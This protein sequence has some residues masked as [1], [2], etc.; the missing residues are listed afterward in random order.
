M[1]TIA[2]RRHARAHTRATEGAFE[3]RHRRALWALLAIT[4]VLYLVGLSRNAWA[5]D[6]YAAAVQAGTR[7][8]K[9][10]FFGSFDAANFI[11]VD[12][13]PASLWVMELSARL[14]GLS[15]WSMLVPQALEGVASVSLLYAAVRRWHGPRAGLIAGA[16]LAV[17]PVAALMF[18]YNN[19][20][21]LL[22]LLL[23]ASGYAMVRAIESGRTRWL[24]AA[25]ALLGFGFL[26]KM[27]Q[28]FLLLPPFAV[29]YLIASPRRPLVRLSQ[30]VAGLSAVVAAAG[31]W[32]A[33]VMLTPATDRP[34]VGGSTD[35]NILQLALGYNGLGRL[36]GNETGSVGFAGN[37]GTGPSFSGSAGL[38][39]LFS[40]DMGGQIGWLL[41]AALL[42]IAALAWLAWRTRR[43]GQPGRDLP[44]L[45]L[46]GGWLVV[47]GGVFSYMAG[48]IHPYYTIA[49]AP[50]IAA[51]VGI[52]ATRLWQ[53]AGSAGAPR[54]GPNALAARCWLAAGVAVTAGWSFTLL[55]RSPS[56]L[57]W[58]RITVLALGLATTAAILVAPQLGM[59][60]GTTARRRLIA[61]LVAA[62][63]LV[64]GLAGPAAYA[65][66][67]IAASH[68]GALPTAGPSVTAAVGGPGGGFAAGA[69]GHAAFGGGLGAP[70][71]TGGGTAGGLGRASGATG[72]AAGGLGGPS[73]AT[74]GAAGGLSG[75]PGAS[76]G[77]PGGL[78]AG[79]GAGRGSGVP[80]GASG[81]GGG[82]GGSTTVS[83]ALTRLLEQN[84]GAYTW[85]A[86]TVG[87][88][89]A[90]PLQLAT[91]DAIMS[92]G[93]FNGTDP[94]PSLAQFERLVADHKI[95]YF[96]GQNAHSFGGGS[97]VA[98][99]IAKWVASHFTSRSIGGEIVYNL[100][101]PSS[102]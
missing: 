55:A 66:D 18:R 48:I 71:S 53:A 23:V 7:S 69:G 46:W 20:D 32:V 58:L 1:T 96:V 62:T 81:P 13:T 25:G 3:R 4:A 41:P 45:L 28:A 84:A 11:T 16:T 15:T 91:G 8:W 50:A 76:N 67:T 85:A 88:E 5:N 82:L 31:W 57:P 86:A 74:G 40:A 34:Y 47:T 90:A 27:L 77:G 33:A 78:P 51:V 94:A 10:F 37:R 2:L 29:A 39:R 83:S 70:P 61:G 98:S 99:A 93:G 102:G 52:S 54:P 95:H 21:A 87:S 24:V 68:A 44:A 65:L 79:G 63:A 59:L 101:E 12:K 72:G 92:I 17:T 26:A 19:P 73:G 43:A 22:T 35:N 38:G 42:G 36:D 89:S 100:A 56:W 64:V 75:A 30:L 49:L 80:G 9:A 60:A 14:F 97:G 6:F